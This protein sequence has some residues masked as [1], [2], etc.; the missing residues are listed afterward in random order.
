[1]QNEL[2]HWLGLIVIFTGLL[3]LPYVLNSFMVRGLMQTMGFR[4]DLPPL[5][6]WAQRA[7]KAHYNAV[8][9]LVLFAPVLIAHAFTA[10]EAQ[11]ALVVNL[12]MLYL[13][14]MRCEHGR[15]LVGRACQI[16]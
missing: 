5:P 14:G 9:N 3:W 10:D 8:E 1:M 4:E 16:G 6:P 11:G 13:L 12:A 7:K 15:N 2:L